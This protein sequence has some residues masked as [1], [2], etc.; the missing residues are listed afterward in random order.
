MV[1]AAVSPATQ[2]IMAQTAILMVITFAADL[3]LLTYRAPFWLVCVV[4]VA[5]FLAADTYYQ[6]KSLGGHEDE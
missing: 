2:K 5:I 3:A 1:V 4:T 6:H